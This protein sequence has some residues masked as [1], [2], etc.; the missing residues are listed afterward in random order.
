[1]PIEHSS[2]ESTNTV[3]SETAGRLYA[4]SGFDSNVAKASPI[5]KAIVDL[6]CMPAKIQRNVFHFRVLLGIYRE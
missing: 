1:M 4:G 3:T 2:D 6:R 5:G